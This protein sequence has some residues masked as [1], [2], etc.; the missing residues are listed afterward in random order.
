MEHSKIIK[1]A[2]ILYKS[3]INLNKIEKLPTESTPK[4]IDEAYSI[5]DQLVNL[6]LAANKE[7]LVIGKKIGCTNK[8]AQNQLNVNEPFFGNILSDNFS[9]SDCTIKSSNFF[10][11]FIE[12]EFSF[13]IKKELD[14]S[15]APHSIET[16]YD[17]IDSIMPSIE[18][19]DSRYNDWTKIG[20]NNL[21]ADNAVHAHWI[22]GEE[23]NNLGLFDLTN[24]FVK[25]YIND[26]MVVEGNSSNVLG[27][28]INSLRWLLNTLAKKQKNLPINS[29]VSTGTCTP[30]IPIQKNNK[31]CADFGKL[32]KINFKYY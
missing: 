9:Q 28:P 1:A 22:Y 32:G 25:L 12:P 20:I 31:I 14:F 21:I 24:H 15:K 13:K 2:N 4:N 5:Q 11:P 16:V 29:Y 19:V 17:S 23:I 30:A 27:N 8:A 18:I 10:S 7:T 6:Y 26:K 3:R